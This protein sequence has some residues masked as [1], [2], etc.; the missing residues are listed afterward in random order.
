MAP[1]RQSQVTS[2]RRRITRGVF[3]GKGSDRLSEMTSELHAG[4][5]RTLWRA[6]TYPRAE[7]ASRDGGGAWRWSAAVPGATAVFTWHRHSLPGRIPHQLGTDPAER[8]KRHV[9]P[10]WAARGGRMPASRP[11]AGRCGRRPPPSANLLPQAD[12]QDT[13]GAGIGARTWPLR[14]VVKFSVSTWAD[15]GGN[16]AHFGNAG[17]AEQNRRST[18][19]SRPPASP[20]GPPARLLIHWRLGLAAATPRGSARLRP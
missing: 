19:Y 4:H 12:A 6:V 15:Y 7:D 13:A 10:G 11:R 20:T 9:G 16:P 2:T 5:D 3:T 17:V 1:P 14:K 18:K 8:A